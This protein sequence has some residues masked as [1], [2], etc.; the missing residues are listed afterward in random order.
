MLPAL[1][2]AC[3]GAD[4]LNATVSTDTYRR[5]QGL[6]YGPDARQRLD[7]YQPASGMAKPPMVVVGA[8]SSVASVTPVFRPMATGLALVSKSLKVCLK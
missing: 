7:V 5:T 2:T 8:P 3:S 4:L 1:L 6:A